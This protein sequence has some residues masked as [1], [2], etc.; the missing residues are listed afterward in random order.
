MISITRTASIA[1]GKAVEAIAYGHE[2]AKYI[3]AKHN[4]TFE[5]LTPI[6]GNPARIAWNARMANLAEWE[7][8]TG[9]LMADKK[10]MEIVSKHSALFLP[11]SVCD[12]LWRTV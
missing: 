7:S 10:Y 5:V 1:P 9:K 6:G 12:H 2:I 11:G 8:V 4:I 3:K